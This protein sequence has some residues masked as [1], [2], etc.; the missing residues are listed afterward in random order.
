MGFLH[1]IAACLCITPSLPNRLISRNYGKWLF[2]FCFHRD[3]SIGRQWLR[4]DIDDWC[5]RCHVWKQRLCQ[6]SDQAR[7]LNSTIQSYLTTCRRNMVHWESLKFLWRT[8]SDILFPKTGK[9]DHWV[10]NKKVKN[11]DLIVSTSNIYYDMLLRTKVTSYNS[12]SLKQH[13]PCWVDQKATIEWTKETAKLM[14]QIEKDTG[15]GV[16]CMRCYM[17]LLFCVVI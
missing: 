2:L 11:S 13:T 5:W 4:P 7:D 6:S 14:W 12:F 3:E 10:A 9:R 17:K 16:Q 1:K 15:F 8:M